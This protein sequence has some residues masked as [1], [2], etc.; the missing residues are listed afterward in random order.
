MND[1]THHGNAQPE[2]VSGNSAR[3]GIT[4][5]GVRYVLLFSLAGVVA[6]FIALAL[7]NSS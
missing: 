5:H 3:Q 1:P 2:I 7:F 6:A 4:G